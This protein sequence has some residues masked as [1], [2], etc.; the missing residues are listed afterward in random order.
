[1]KTLDVDALLEK[2]PGV[3]RERIKARLTQGKP[4]RSPAMQPYGSASPYGAHRMTVDEKSKLNE[5]SAVQYK[6]R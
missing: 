6:T 2:N 4:A 5:T 1:M 3:D